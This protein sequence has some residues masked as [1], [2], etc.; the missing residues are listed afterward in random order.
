MNINQE[1][2]DVHF[3]K[4]IESFSIKISELINVGN[5]EEILYLNKSRLDLI[6]KFKDKNNKQFK[7]IISNINN[8]NYK[9]IERI[10]TKFRSLKAER[11]NFIK[12]FKAYNY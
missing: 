1:K 3:L 9:N 7:F 8:D 6:K 10:E 5:Y 2:D 11:G 12:R 4:K